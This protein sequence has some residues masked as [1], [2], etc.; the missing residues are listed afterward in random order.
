MRI[1][2]GQVAEGSNISNL[3]VASGTSFPSNANVAELFYRTDE[4]KLYVHNGTTWVELS[5]SPVTTYKHTQL[6]AST[7]W[8]I[9]HNLNSI[10]IL[11]NI[12]VDIGENIYKPILPDDFDF[13]DSNTITVTFSSPQSGYVII[14]KI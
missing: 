1:Y 5:V 2:G 7:S 4:S 9:I 6:S 11:Y 12:Y 14:K 3:T 13:T 8:T 10:D